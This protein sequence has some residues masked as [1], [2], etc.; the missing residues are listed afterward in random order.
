MDILLFLLFLAVAYFLQKPRPEQAID[1][2]VS[3]SP[4]PASESTAPSVHPIPSRSYLD[5]LADSPA[6]TDTASLSAV[7]PINTV[8]MPPVST[9]PAIKRIS[10]R[11]PWQQAIIYHALISPPRS[12]NPYYF[13]E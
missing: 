1:E 4:A 10:K 5:P 2:T 13:P 6:E 9:P 11:T 7:H 3:L 12:V 8:S